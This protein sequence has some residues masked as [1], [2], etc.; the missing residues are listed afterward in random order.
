MK[1]HSSPWGAIQSQQTV[2]PGIEFVSTAS[3][4][5][6]YVSDD[7]LA[8]LPAAV[9]DAERFNPPGNW[10]EEDCEV[11]IV[12]VAFPE[13]AATLGADRTS[14]L[15]SLKRFYPHIASALGE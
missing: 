8:E 7:R 3:H 9:R 14:A 11:A 1:L 6:C 15:R 2:A 5:G 12:I 4:G 13:V 10:Y